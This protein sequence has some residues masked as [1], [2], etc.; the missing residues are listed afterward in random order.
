MSAKNLDQQGRWRSKQISFRLSQ[1]E[2]A[3]IETAV[4]IAGL[5]KQEYIT[6]RLTD[7]NVVVHGNPKVYRGLKLEMQ[8]ILSEL[9][10]LTAGES[11][12]PELLMRIDLIAAVM[13]GMKTEEGG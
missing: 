8:A 3:L 7:M 5:S 12:Q 11:P 4:H 2:N 13:D 1:E 10:R 6:H 9:E